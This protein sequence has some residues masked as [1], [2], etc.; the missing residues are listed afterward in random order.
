M[1][2]NI[3]G[4]LYSL[5][6][7]KV[8][9]ILN[10]T[11]DSFF[12]GGRFLSE[13]KILT[14]VV[15]MIENGMDI[16]D[17]GG[18]SSRPGAKTLSVKE[19]EERVI[20]ILKIL[21]KEFKDLIISVDTFR[22][23]IARKSIENGVDIINDISAGEIDEEIMKIVSNYNTPYIIMHM[24]GN[25]QTMQKNPNYDDVCREIISYLAQRVK[26]AREYKI[27]DLIIDPG[28]GF[29]KTLEHNYEI[30]SNLHHF[31]MIDLPLL[32]GFSRKSMITKALKIEKEFAL[33]GT[34]I[35]NTIALIKGAKILRVHD[36]KE[37]KE[38]INL[39][40]LTINSS[41]NS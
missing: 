10:L 3:R 33:N 21:K 5:E 18:Y 35:L 37:A 12:D 29:G 20:P 30:L 14:H 1:N 4:E 7:P 23:E 40:N 38:C 26:K 28:F 34:S 16:L 31:E 22:A 19:E 24:K 36:V 8:M 27:N 39:Y 32:V 11:P 15:S 2:I 17:I 25:P 6:S 13:K 41:G 9:G